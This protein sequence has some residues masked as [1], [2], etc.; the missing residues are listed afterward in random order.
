LID[1]IEDTLLSAIEAAASKPGTPLDKLFD[2]FVS[3]LSYA[4][5]RRGITFIV[6]NETLSF[7]DRKLRDKMF[8]VIDRYLK[9]IRSML[10]EG[11]VSGGFRKDLD[12]VSSSIAFF[13]MIQATVTLWA[14]SGFKYSLGRERLTERFNIYKKGVIGQ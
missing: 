2:I 14:L 3:H 13:G 10:E 1:N 5:Q 6:M 4:E 9:T 12:V 11:M 8:G 7:N